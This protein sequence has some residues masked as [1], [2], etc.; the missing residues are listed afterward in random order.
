MVIEAPF[1]QLVADM[2]KRHVSKQ[3]SCERVQQSHQILVTRSPP[4]G[5]SL[6][7]LRI[8]F[9]NFAVKSLE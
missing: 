3:D 2:L 9:A 1:A 6:R 5:P 8:F 4:Q 7:P